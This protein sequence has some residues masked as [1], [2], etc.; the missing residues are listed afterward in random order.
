LTR[1]STIP[2]LIWPETPE[3]LEA[4]AALSHDALDLMLAAL[5]TGYDQLRELLTSIDI[6]D[7][8]D[9]AE[10]NITMLLH[11]RTAE[12]LSGYEPFTCRHAF[13]ENETR[14]RPPAQAPEYDI[15][16]VLRSN[17][18]IAWPVE[19]KVLRSDGAIAA[20]VADVNEQY[21]TCRYAPFSGSGAMVAYLLKGEVNVLFRN[22]STALA[23]DLRE[24][25]AFERRAHR[26]SHHAR[27]VP[28]G[29]GYPTAFECHHLAMAINV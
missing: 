4:A 9:E 22:L 20:Y 6:G 12:A 21:L 16:F 13:R 17:E 18:R 1:R 23:A 7:G 28:V 24:H 27:N 11:V 19:A 25:P 26:V 10:R 15:A 5:W 14:Q 8:G 29:R 2:E 3:F